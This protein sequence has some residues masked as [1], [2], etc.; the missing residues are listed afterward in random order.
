MDG[1][2]FATAAPPVESDPARADIACF[3]GFVAKRGGD[4]TEQ[5]VG[6]QGALETLGWS[7]PNLPANL[8]ANQRVI[9]AD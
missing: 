9:P 2:S 8:P 1:L 5:R 3:I 6:L 7:R 4:V